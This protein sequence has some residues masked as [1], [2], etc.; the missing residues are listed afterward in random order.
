M[1]T[2]VD[3]VVIGASLAGS[4]FALNMGCQGKQIVLID[5]TAVRSKP[6]G[7]GLSKL[8]I[9]LLAEL[10]VHLPKEKH[11]PLEGYNVRYSSR[12]LNVNKAVGA[13]VQ[14]SELGQLLTDKLSEHPNIRLINSQHYKLSQKEDTWTLAAG[15]QT[16]NS[17]TLVLACGATSPIFD[18]LGIIGEQ[19]TETRLAA[20]CHYEGSFPSPLT[21][22]QV[23]LRENY[24]MLI[25]PLA[26]NQFNLSFMA[27]PQHQIKK[28]E[29]LQFM[30][31]ELAT[32]GFLGQATSL[33]SGRVVHQRLQ[34]PMAQRN[35]IYLIGDACEQLDPIGG[36][37]MTHALLSAKLL[38]KYLSK[39]LNL[40]ELEKNALIREHSKIIRPCRGFTRLSFLT[41]VA[42]TNLF[43]RFPSIAQR[44]ATHL[45]AQVHQGEPSKSLIL[46]FIGY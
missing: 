25:T 32:L 27:S 9:G 45:S 15:T 22:V 4:A 40:T 31:Q 8:G 11:C 43:L 7:E 26:T 18:E 19:S 33:P 2:E 16:F 12:Q 5:K 35:N 10:G 41:M 3:L 44:M 38:T 37:G 14:R 6:C 20:S 46:N 24:Q 30:N 1:K 29:V 42:H 23:V 28:S 21:R 17:K 13:G 34:R 36:M 39:N